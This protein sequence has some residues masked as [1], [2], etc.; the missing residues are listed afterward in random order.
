MLKSVI[1]AVVPFTAAL[2]LISLAQPAFAHERRTVGAYQTV[3]GWADEPAFSGLPN[4]VQFRLSE[5]AGEPVTDLGAEDLKVEVSYED[6]KIGPLAISP[7]F[8][9]GAF[10]DPGD[11]QADLMPSRPGTY[12]FRITGTIKGQPFDETYTSGEE[13]FDSPETTS[14]I[15][16]PA[17]DP[18]V[19]EL[20]TGLDR[21]N[22]RIAEAESSA[23]LAKLGAV[24]GGLALIVAIAAFRA[25]KAA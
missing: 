8:R 17:K 22:S 12:S 10:G 20:A 7:A 25:R 3:V 16:F 23:S 2:A 6:Q 24:L 5:A 13:T 14:T 9:V 4:S 19:G 15:A 1:R 11:Y 21:A 18:S